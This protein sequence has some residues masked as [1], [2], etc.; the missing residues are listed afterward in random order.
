MRRSPHPALLRPTPHTLALYTLMHTHPSTLVWLSKA[1]VS[2]PVP[3]T[4]RRPN[5]LVNVTVNPE[6]VT[7][8]GVAL[9]QPVT[10][11]YETGPLT[12]T[13]GSVTS[14][15]ASALTGG[16]WSS[17]LAPWTSGAYE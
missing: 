14:E 3:F 17:T 8:D 12:I 6:L 2:L 15:Q 7:F 5:L 16:A 9:A 1:P 10:A 4:L 11:Q 13:I